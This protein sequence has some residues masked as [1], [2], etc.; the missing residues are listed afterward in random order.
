MAPVHSWVSTMRTKAW[1]A[2]E[3]RR[4]DT[5]TRS[6]CR[7]TLPSVSGGGLTP[8]TTKDYVV[9]LKEGEYLC[10]CPLNPTP[11]YRLDVKG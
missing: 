2:A 7:V 11:D 9:E 10:S 8:G 1:T 3:N 4:P 5:V 6:I